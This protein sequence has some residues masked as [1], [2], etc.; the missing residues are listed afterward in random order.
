MPKERISWPAI[1]DANPWST[2]SH[3]LS[4]TAQAADLSPFDV[5]LYI[6][7]ATQLGRLVIEGIYLHHDFFCAL[8][9]APSSLLKA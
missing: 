4:R 1:L 5:Y 3:R 8:I 2:A 9:A 7:K 6:I